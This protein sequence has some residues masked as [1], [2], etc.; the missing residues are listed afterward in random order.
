MWKDIP[1]SRMGGR[2]SRG[3][4][5]LG[6]GGLEAGSRLEAVSG[7][8][9]QEPQRR[10]QSQ[11]HGVPRSP[12]RPRQPAA[13]PRRRACSC[14]ATFSSSAS[15]ADR[16]SSSWSSGLRLALPSSSFFSSG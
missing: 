6:F 7:L 12:G 8:C 3:R 11:D 10:Q 16:L 2:E 4:R 5:G 15:M 13:Q 9:D 1:G 14:C